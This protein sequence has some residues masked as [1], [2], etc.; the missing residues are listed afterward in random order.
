VQNL[1]YKIEGEKKKEEYLKKVWRGGEKGRKG[2]KFEGWLL[3]GE[4]FELPM[5]VVKVCVW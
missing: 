4:V 3:V 1:K 5:T 2:Q